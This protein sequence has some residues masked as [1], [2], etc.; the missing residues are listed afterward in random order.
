MVSLWQDLIVKTV[1]VSTGAAA[2]AIAK[3]QRKRSEILG[4]NNK[5]FTKV[6]IGWPM[7]GLKSENGVQ[8]LEGLGNTC[9]LEQD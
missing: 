4:L 7:P 5:D 6:G 2:L 9:E 1:S 8:W 3:S